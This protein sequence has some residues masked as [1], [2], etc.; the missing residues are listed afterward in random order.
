[1]RGEPVRASWTGECRICEGLIQ[2]GDQVAHTRVHG[3]VH[4]RC[5]KGE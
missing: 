2:P 1:M 5:G 3:W 4:Q